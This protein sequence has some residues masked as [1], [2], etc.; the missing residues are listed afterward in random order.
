MRSFKRFLLYEAYNEGE[1]ME[2]IFAIAVA[3]FLAD[4]NISIDKITRARKRVLPVGGE[5]QVFKKFRTF[6]NKK[7]KFKRAC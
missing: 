5:S 1:I 7:N 4:D 2:A 6:E 3:N